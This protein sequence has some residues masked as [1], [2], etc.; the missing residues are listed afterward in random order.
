[1]YL[2]NLIEIRTLIRQCIS[3]AKHT[4]GSKILNQF[5][6]T[7]APFTYDMLLIDLKKINDHYFAVLL[8]ST[9][10]IMKSIDGMQEIK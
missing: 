9:W 5:I 4:R 10:F 6:G 2:F 8:N 7:L 3:I 1:M